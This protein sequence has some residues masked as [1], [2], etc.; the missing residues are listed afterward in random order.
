MKHK[1][2]FLVSEF[3]QAGGE[4]QAFEFNSVIDKNIYEVDIL[5]NL[6]LKFDLNREDYYFDKHLELGSKI[7]FLDEFKGKK[8]NRNWF[9][10]PKNVEQN[11]FFATKEKLSKFCEEYDFFL[12]FGEYLY[13]SIHKFFPSRVIE[14]SIILVHNSRF[15][16]PDNYARIN[17][18]EN[19]HFVSG[20]LEDEILNEFVEFG[21]YKHTYLPLSINCSLSVPKRKEKLISSK[22]KR[23]GIFT[24][25]TKY[26][27]LD[28]FY[29][30]LH[31]L[32]NRGIE[33]ELLIFGNG[34][35]EELEFNKCISYLGL[36]ND[37]TFL[38][39]QKDMLNAAVTSELDL[40]WF[41]SYYG[42][43][44]GYA[45]FDICMAE[46]PQ[47]FWNF[48]PGKQKKDYPAFKSFENLDQFVE[49]SSSLISDEAKIIEIGKLQRKAI[50]ETR[51]MHEHIKNIEILIEQQ[52]YDNKNKQ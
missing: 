25:L 18:E 11:Q 4:R 34:T 13:S 30:A 52:I 37:V 40:V 7:F 47:V 3:W 42:V 50:I 20:F 51:N 12:F 26:K 38:G 46:I 41:H 2:L 21:L 43:P 15:Q 45:S 5:C 22:K 35:P 23:I 48:T 32:K 19:L 14:N 29:Y 8:N 28:L 31:L 44:G 33:V 1:I 16:V 6:P 17:K 39:H 24:R 9:G 10:L 49:Y 36:E 27:P